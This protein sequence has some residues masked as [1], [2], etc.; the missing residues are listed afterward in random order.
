MEGRQQCFKGFILFEVT[1]KGF[2]K[3][4]AAVDV[5]GGDESTDAFKI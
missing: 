2:F 5:A 3:R 1:L 4:H